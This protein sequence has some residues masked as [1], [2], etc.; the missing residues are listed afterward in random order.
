MDTQI[1]PHISASEVISMSNICYACMKDINGDVCPH[2]HFDNAE[3]TPALHHLRPNTTVGGRYKLGRVLGEGGFGITYVGLDTSLGIR[4]AVKEYYPVGYVM[5]EH[6]GSDSLHSFKGEQEEFFLTHKSKFI[7]EARRLARLSNLPGIVTV[8]DFFEQNNTAYIVMDYIDG[9]TYKQYLKTMGGSLQS[10]QVFDMMKPVMMSLIKVHEA[11]IIHRD[12][13]PD[14]IMI[15][16]DGFVKLIDFGSARDFDV[17]NKSM[18]VMLKQGYSPEEQYRSRGA[19]GPWT[20]VYSLCATMYKCMTGRTPDE[21]TERLRR[22][23]L[24][25]PSQLG[26]SIDP[27]KEMAL[28]HGLAVCAEDR[29]SNVSELYDA[30]YPRVTQ[31]PDARTTVPE[32]TKKPPASTAYRVVFACVLLSVAVIFAVLIM[33]LTGDDAPQ[34]PSEALPVSTIAPRETGTPEPITLHPNG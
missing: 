10:E 13:S 7:E 16:T 24:P 30:L 26:V 23:E 17:Q 15:S 18:S 1:Y 6:A 4:V 25:T 32:A 5:R 28:M 21:S 22:D 8:K 12:I 3:Y 14:N 33:M 34:E 31:T 11:G 20:D 19:Q 9:Q 29:I 27:S 2:C